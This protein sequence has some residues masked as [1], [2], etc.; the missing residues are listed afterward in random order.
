M[1]K[2]TNRILS[3]IIFIIPIITIL[4]MLFLPHLI[5][6]NF[7]YLKQY[8]DLYGY[9]D[10]LSYGATALSVISTVILSCITVAISRKANEVSDRM[11][12]IEEERMT[13]YL[14][15]LREK[16]NISECKD[17]DSK[18]KVKLHIRNLGE[19]PIQNIYLSR[20][21]LNHKKIK[22]LYSNE[23]IQNTIIEQL[24]KI[25]SSKNDT[26]DYNLT[27]IAGLRE[28]VIVHSKTKNREKIE[29]EEHTPFSE[30]LFFNIDKQEVGTPIELFITM[31]NIAGKVF[32]QRTKLFIVQRNQDKKYFLTMHSKR[33]ET[34]EL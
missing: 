20:T 31:Q 14:D 19:Y 3:F 5:S 24:E 15:I 4:F 12:K 33:I 29:E 17:D 13:P 30:N 9:P 27:C 11:L 23:E 16:S 18:L 7:D 6:G 22:N 21:K 32:L 8:I 25:D 26:V 2:F 1:K 34:I 28:M 10:I